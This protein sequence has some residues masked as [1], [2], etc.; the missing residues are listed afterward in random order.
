MLER[1]QGALRGLDVLLQHRHG[2][3][4][5][6]QPSKVLFEEPLSSVTP[7]LGAAR[8]LLAVALLWAVLLCACEASRTSVLA[9]FWQESHRV[10][11]QN[12]PKQVSNGF[13]GPISLGVSAK[14]TCQSL[15]RPPHPSSG[16]W[17]HPRA[18]SQGPAPG[19]SCQ[20]NSLRRAKPYGGRDLFCSIAKSEHEIGGHHLPPII[21]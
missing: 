12:C 11:I 14:F 9:R 17:I 4:A 15:G 19:T 21:P 13:F 16:C 8:R 1:W 2:V 5:S 18:S 7:F 20:G 3:L 10:L 6:F